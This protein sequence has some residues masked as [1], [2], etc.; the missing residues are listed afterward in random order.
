MQLIRWL[1][2]ILVWL[3]WISYGR[4]YLTPFFESWLGAEIGFV[5]CSALIFIG[6]WIMW[7]TILKR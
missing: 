5:A 7:R 4:Q 3:V 6:G 2:L 1:I